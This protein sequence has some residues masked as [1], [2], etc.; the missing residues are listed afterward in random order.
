MA[1]WYGAVL[2]PHTDWSRWFVCEEVVPL[3]NRFVIFL[4]AAIAV[5][6]GGIAYFLFTKSEGDLLD[7]LAGRQQMNSYFMDTV[8]EYGRETELFP[9]SSM[10]RIYWELGDMIDPIAVEIPVDTQSLY[11]LYLLYKA[12]I[13]LTDEQKYEIGLVVWKYQDADS[14]L[15][16]HSAENSDDDDWLDTYYSIR[17]IDPYGIEINHREKI[18]W[19]VEEELQAINQET[20]LK[21]MYAVVCLADFFEVEY[22]LDHR[23]LAAFE[24]I[25]NRRDIGI[26][27]IIDFMYFTELC[28]YSDYVPG[29]DTNIV[30][31]I[32]GVL[33]NVSDLTIIRLSLECL[34]AL[35]EL[36]GDTEKRIRAY[37]EG[38]DKKYKLPDNTYCYIPNDS[39]DF[40]GTY[41]AV[42][43]Y[44]LLGERVPNLQDLERDML[45]RLKDYEYLSSLK[46]EDLYYLV[47]AFDSLGGKHDEGSRKAVLNR[48]AAIEYEKVSGRELLC[49]CAI[50]ARVS[51]GVSEIPEDVVRCVRERIRGFDVQKANRLE[52]YSMILLCDLM[53]EEVRQDWLDRYIALRGSVVSVIEA[54][55]ILLI[56]SVH[57]SD[58]GSMDKKRLRALKTKWGYPISVEDPN[59]SLYTT[60]CGMLS[61]GML[62]NREY[63][64]PILL[65]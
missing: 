49:G 26:E 52:L 45:W 29:L 35:D 3:R 39:V 23:F 34:N 62:D 51:S 40:L 42:A 19:R 57:Y 5:V 2:L 43:I 17:A 6:A 54:Y 64:L 14:G 44:R 47:M 10:R 32:R 11:G 9:T 12:A 16:H 59:I 24:P 48:L 4:V 55:Y 65:Y 38:L 58:T 25:F 8:A 20:S 1:G 13:P 7:H 28:G 56:D 22:E 60:M 18:L 31:D 61:E 63:P 21:R 30:N 33:L 27:Y 46:T 53:G 37:L 36:D 50:Y 41:G 15:F